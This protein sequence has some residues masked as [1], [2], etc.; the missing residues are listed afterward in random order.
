MDND[1]VKDSYENDEITTPLKGLIG[2]FPVIGYQWPLQL[3]RLPLKH[4]RKR[5]FLV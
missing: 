4:Y 3:R 2:L 5:F 1:L